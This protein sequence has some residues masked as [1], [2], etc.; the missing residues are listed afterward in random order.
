MSL[1]RIFETQKKNK[2]RY[3]DIKIRKIILKNLKIIL[4]YFNGILSERII[5]LKSRV[6]KKNLKI[7]ILVISNLKYILE[8]KKKIRKITP[9]VLR[10]IFI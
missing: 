8:K 3:I 5:F 10:T 2:K 4:L 9:P 6:F 1:E 7:K